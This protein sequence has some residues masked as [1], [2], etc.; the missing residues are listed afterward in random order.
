MAELAV[1]VSACL[2]GWEVRG[3]TLA[4]PGRFEAVCSAMPRPVLLPF[5]MASGWFT[6]RALPC[7]AAPFD[8]ALLEP[9]GLHPTLPALAA[10]RIADTIAPDDLPGCQI[11]IAAHGSRT[12]RGSAEATVR[13]TA[14][15]SG[16]LPCPSARIGFLEEAP[17]IADVARGMGRNA[18]CLP[19]FALSSGHVTEDLPRALDSAGFA[20]SV[21]PPLIDWP[22]VP[23]LLGEAIAR[24]R[25]L[26]PCP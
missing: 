17:Y 10:A 9:F 14:A 11:L 16:L 7:R 15:L 4:A 8:V 6:T 25:S 5:F 21:L 26:A 13:F 12:A 24:T 20:G 19:L 1:R 23:A 18:L 22:E 3:T 2:P